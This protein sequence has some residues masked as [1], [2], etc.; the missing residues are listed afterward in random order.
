[1]DDNLT[2]QQRAEQVR[3][4]LRE[5]GWYLLAGL[6]LGLAGL[7]GWRQWTEYDTTHA[8]KASALYEE[9][10]S[11]IR[12]DRTTRAEEI[13]EELAAQYAS[14]PYLDQARLA[15]AKMKLDRGQPEEAV[16]YLEQVAKDSDSA[17]IADIA[18]LRVARVLAQQE[19]YDD[20]LKVL[21][22]P[23]DSAFEPQF[24]EV[25]GDVY[26]AMGRPDEAR[27]EYEAA[28]KGDQSGAGDQAFLRAK[29]AELSGGVVPEAMAEPAAP[30]MN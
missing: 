4:W 16:K 24:H 11:A 27:A 28:L 1:M 21:A 10:L 3:I 18:R 30:A 5:N 8:E 6:A 26:Y 23:K 17:E 13:A 2:D 19:K 29:L 20:A 22:V 7:F 12:V 25:R 15:M 14:T 9:M